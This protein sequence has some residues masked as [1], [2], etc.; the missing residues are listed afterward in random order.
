[1]R[2]F[3]AIATG[4]AA[5][6][7]ACAA[8][9]FPVRVVY[10]G[11][12][13]QEIR[14]QIS[15]RLPD[16]PV[17]ES[18]L[19]ARR[20][21]RRAKAV[22]EGI[23]NAY[24]YFDPV[25]TPSVVGEGTDARPQLDVEPGAQFAVRRLVIRYQGDPPR[26]DDQDKARA[27]ISLQPGM[28]AV[29]AE[30]ID[31]ERQ[32]EARLRELGY[33]YAGTQGREVIGDREGKTISVRYTVFAGPRV[34][35][36]DVIYP[37]GIRTRDRYLD[38]L[39]PLEEGELYDP[40]DLALYN[41]RLAE[42]RLFNSSLAKLADE[43][44]SVDPDGTEVRAVR[45]L[46]D[47]RKRNTLTLGAGWDTAEGFGV[48][49][50]LLRR[51]LTGRGDL[52]IGTARAA[53]R[54]F[55]LDL[56]WRRPNELGFGK[57][58]SLFGGISDENTDAFNQQTANAG[59]GIEVIE[60]PV[61]QYA[62]GAE[63]RYIRQSGESER[64]DFQTV[65]LNGSARID[66]AD[67]L[68][69]PRRGWRAEGRIKPTY[70]FSDQGDSPYIRAVAQGRAYLPLSAE[71]RFVAAGRLRLGT[72]VGAS[73]DNVPGDDR[74]FSGGGGSVRGYAFQA[75]GPFD[76]DDVPLGGRSLTE[77]SLEGRARITDSIGAVAF[78]DAGNVS[79][80]EYPTFDNLR[81]GAGV[82]VRYMTPAGPIR[83]DVAT[84]LN[85]SDRDEAV[86]IYISI[87]QAF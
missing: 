40:S 12:V 10:E 36:G 21:A 81:V 17:A 75:I 37:D 22:V 31:Q 67:S 4:L 50:E 38:R 27:A 87:G 84:P 43:P 19:H 1:M 35:F 45:L 51:N 73:V 25:V 7:W 77:A 61:F 23:F 52:L 64:R 34:R 54:E 14:E 69:D 86:Q 44:T 15:D 49:A 63:A 41:S 79:D 76:A 71:G 18:P 83:L 30:V 29:A 85:P 70:A 58:L 48:N 11:E 3:I 39:N 6:F 28:A 66:R 5:L 60:G 80:S 56:V 24:G 74:F 82:G 8:S 26:Q 57:G 65:S 72:L 53:E 78:I 33:A 47:E 2:I 62:Y 32:I 20:Q 59:F 16:E 68:L 46:L 42:T 9:A 55:G 13:P